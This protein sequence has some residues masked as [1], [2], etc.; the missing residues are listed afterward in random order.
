[1]CVLL[2]IYFREIIWK[3]QELRGVEETLFPVMLRS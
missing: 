1:M 3:V 2:P